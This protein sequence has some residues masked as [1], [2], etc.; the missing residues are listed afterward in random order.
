M[1]QIVRQRSRKGSEEVGAEVIIVMSFLAAIS[2]EYMRF[3]ES[4]GNRT[5]M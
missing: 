1:V 4:I 2:I 3:Y 5:Y